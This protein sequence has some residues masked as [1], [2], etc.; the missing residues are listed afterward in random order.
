MFRL[1]L[2]AELAD[3]LAGLTL[4]QIVKLAASDQLLCFF[5]NWSDADILLM[6]EGLTP[7]A[8][9]FRSA[10]AHE[11]VTRNWRYCPRLHIDLFGNTRGT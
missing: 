7:P 3:L 10:L 4:A 2:S 5:R 1:G 11:C 8:P 6:P 9:A